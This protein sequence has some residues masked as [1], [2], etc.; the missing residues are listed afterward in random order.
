M[1]QVRIVGKRVEECRT[2]D[3]YTYFYDPETGTSSYERPSLLGYW[4]KLRLMGVVTGNGTV[5]GAGIELGGVWRGSLKQPEISDTVEDL[6]NWE[7]CVNPENG[8]TYFYNKSSGES[9]YT[10]PVFAKDA[11]L[12]ADL[13]A[14]TRKHVAKYPHSA[15]LALPDMSAAGTVA[16]T[17]D[18]WEAAATDDGTPYWCVMSSCPVVSCR[19]VS[20]R[21]V[22]CRVV[23]CRVVSCRV[24]SCRVVS[25]RVAPHIPS[26]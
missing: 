9:T 18:D 7:E 14:I 25:C 3:G 2:D 5:T 1:R 19:V 4:N 22:S 16:T 12:W 6:N 26:C 17:V 11:R 10:R 23:S 13:G 21:V 24:V 20:C 15:L 8:A